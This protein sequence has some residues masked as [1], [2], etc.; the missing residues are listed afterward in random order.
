[1]KTSSTEDVLAEVW[2]IKDSLSASLG[3]SLRAT[4][5]ALYAEQK[6]HPGD[7]VNL[8]A[9]PRQTKTQETTSGASKSPV[10]R[11]RRARPARV[12]A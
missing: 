3:H 10:N 7:F 2:A 8:G 12:S 4:C 1:M 5:R 9:S 6:K 11:K